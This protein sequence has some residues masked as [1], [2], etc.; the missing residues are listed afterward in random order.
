MNRPDEL[1][2]SAAITELMKPE[3][4][5]DLTAVDSRRT[6][7]D[8]GLD[9]TG[10]VAVAEGLRERIGLVIEPEEFFDHPTVED[11][12]RHLLARLGRE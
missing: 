8:L 9:S 4:E 3:L 11:L 6:F 12:S 7:T 10:V 1:T 5:D 2:I